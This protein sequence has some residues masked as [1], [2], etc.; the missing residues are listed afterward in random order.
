MFKTIVVSM[1]LIA[2]SCFADDDLVIEAK[3][4]QDFSS[5]YIA[6]INFEIKNNT[7]DWIILSNPKVNFSEKADK[8]IEVLNG[9]RLAVWA[10][11]AKEKEQELKA[12]SKLWATF[13][14]G[15]I[16][17]MYSSS[18]ILEKDDD[19]SKNLQKNKQI[20]PKG[21]IYNDNIIVPPGISVKRF[22]IIS[23]KNHKNYGYLNQLTLN[24]E[25]NKNLLKTKLYFRNSQFNEDEPK[26]IL[27]NKPKNH[28][29]WQNDL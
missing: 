17:T 4:N 23:S 5:K 8:N 16:G 12:S 13:W 7:Q 2:S 28:Y 11:Y 3:I 6:M 14:F 15:G 1:L 27:G 24:Y 19:L 10:E 22:F 26:D 20:Y 9:K 18:T 29:V 25:Q 21:H